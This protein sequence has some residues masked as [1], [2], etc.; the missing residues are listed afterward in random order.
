[1]SARK[2]IV[3]LTVGGIA[4]VVAIAL[5]LLGTRAGTQVTLESAGRKYTLQVAATPAARELGLGK[6]MSL[7][8]NRGM[9]FVFSS[10]QEQCFWMKDMHFP[11]DMIWVS[12]THRVEYVETAVSP[13]TYPHIFCPDVM[14]KYVIELNAGQASQAGIRTGKTL[15]F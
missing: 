6:R 3:L 8:D 10:S 1:V 4:L 11:L 14:A 5:S 9:L 15:R 13:T 2:R 12:S 7:A